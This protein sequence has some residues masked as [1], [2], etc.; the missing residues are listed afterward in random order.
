[1]QPFV[2][3]YLLLRD[4]PGVKKLKTKGFKEYFS[5]EDL[6]NLQDQEYYLFAKKIQCKANTITEKDFHQM[7]IDLKI[8]LFDLYCQIFTRRN[9]NMEMLKQQVKI[10]SD[11]KELLNMRYNIILHGAPGTGKTFKRAKLLRK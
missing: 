10:T 11:I 7:I 1:M 5:K 3:A 2:N 4:C 6:L 8:D 9:E